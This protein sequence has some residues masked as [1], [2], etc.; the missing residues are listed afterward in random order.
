MTRQTCKPHHY[1]SEHIISQLVN[2]GDAFPDRNNNYNNNGGGANTNV[3]AATAATAAATT[4]AARLLHTY[5][6]V[7]PAAPDAVVV[8]PGM[9]R[10]QTR[11][12]SVS[13][14]PSLSLSDITRS[15]APDAPGDPRRKGP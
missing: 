8:A 11:P 10:D 1:Q 4:T 3:S 5:R 12:C 6:D 15:T 9:Q 13:P 2:V 14:P 7:S